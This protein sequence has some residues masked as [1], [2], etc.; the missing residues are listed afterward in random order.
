MYLVTEGKYKTNQL[1]Y[2]SK[3][4]EYVYL[5]NGREQWRMTGDTDLLHYF[6]EV[7]ANTRICQYY[8]LMKYP[9]F[10]R[11]TNDCQN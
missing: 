6:N 10:A 9:V 3:T 5:R 8:E 2:D 4:H 11:Y 1:G 7:R